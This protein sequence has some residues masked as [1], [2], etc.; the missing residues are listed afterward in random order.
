MSSDEI[1]LSKLCLQNIPVIVAEFFCLVKHASCDTTTNNLTHFPHF[2]R[3]WFCFCS[4]SFSLKTADYQYLFSRILFIHF[5][6]GLLLSTLFNTTD[7]VLFCPINSVSRHKRN[8][9]KH[10]LSHIHLIFYII[11]HMR[12]V[13]RQFSFYIAVQF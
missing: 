4:R 8:H 10:V 11:D 7:T 9:L 3:F 1:S 2:S 6:L 12:P 13:N 5:L